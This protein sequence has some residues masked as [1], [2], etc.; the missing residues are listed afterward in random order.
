M[1]IKISSMVRFSDIIYH[2]HFQENKE[3]ENKFLF[4]LVPRHNFFWPK[5]QMFYGHCVKPSPR[6]V[7]N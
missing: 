3:R 2:N 5:L 1:Q 4:D 7:G 6:F